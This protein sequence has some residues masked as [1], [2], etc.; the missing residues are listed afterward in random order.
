MAMARILA[1]LLLLTTFVSNTAWAFN[2]HFDDV[3]G[4]G[5]TMTNTND[6]GVD[7]GDDSP[8]CADHCHHGTFH[9]LGLHLDQ[10]GRHIPQLRFVASVYHDRLITHFLSLPIKPPRA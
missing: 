3:N 7:T 9:L 1:T 6:D 4:G 5:V 2:V 8:A 10:D